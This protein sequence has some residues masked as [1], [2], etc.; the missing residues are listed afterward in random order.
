MKR[1][2]K[3]DLKFWK[4]ERNKIW[5]CKTSR[6]IRSQFAYVQFTFTSISNITFFNSSNYFLP[7]RATIL[8]K[9]SPDGYHE[10]IS[11]PLMGISD[12]N[13]KASSKNTI[14]Q[15][16]TYGIR[17]DTKKSARCMVERAEETNTS[18]ERREKFENEKY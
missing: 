18:V 4:I 15:L 17:R 7:N 10:I 8:F 5:R 6:E 14:S 12:L 13:A 1:G 2:E 11:I 16:H 3:R 9:D